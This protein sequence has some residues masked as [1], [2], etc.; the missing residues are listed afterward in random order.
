M[1]KHQSISTTGKTR[2]EWIDYDRGLSIVLVSF[3]HAYESISNSGF[4]MANYPALEYA[5]VFLFGF[6]MPMFFIASGMF[7][8]GSIQKKGLTQYNVSRLQTILYPM[9]IWG[10]IQL[11]LQIIF[12]DYTNVEYQASDYLWLLID[13]RRTGQFWYLNTLFFVG[14]LYAIAKVKIKINSREQLAVGLMMYGTVA[15]LRSEGLYLG[16]IMDILQ[17]YLFFAIG[18]LISDKLRNQQYQSFYASTYLLVLLIPAFIIIQYNFTAINLNEKS[19]YF[20]EHHMPFFYLFVALI[21]CALSMNISLMLAKFNRMGFLKTVGF[22]SIHI[23]CM[24]IIMMAMTR[25]VLIKYVHLESVSMLIILVLA[26]GILLPILAY[27]VLNGIN[28]WWLF[29]L[30]KPSVQSEWKPADAK[31]INPLKMWFK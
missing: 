7:L 24:Q 2:L 30:K 31:P 1:E 10:V 23:Y 17:Y 15:L 25:M 27:N 29:S 12:S 26:T 19:H 16:F 21:G 3:R 14:T 13:P 28:A 9:F 22:H 18:D 5:N 20:V 4:D 11:S 6:R 8:S